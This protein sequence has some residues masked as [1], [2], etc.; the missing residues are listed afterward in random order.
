MAAWPEPGW[1]FEPG[2]P[3]LARWWDGTA[4]GTYAPAPMPPAPPAIDRFGL[5]VE[6]TVLVQ[7]SAQQLAA[8]DPATQVWLPPTGAPANASKS[9]T[10]LIVLLVIALLLIL[11][12]PAI[13]VARRQHHKAQLAAAQAAG[14]VPSNPQGP[15]AA[16]VAT[17][18]HPIFTVVTPPPAGYEG[19]AAVFTA[20]GVGPLTTPVF[21]LHGGLV[22]GMLSQAGD[23]AYFY[24][25]PENGQ[26]PAQPNETCNDGCT[27]RGW[28]PYRAPVPAGKYRLRVKAAAGTAWTFDLTEKL[29]AQLAYSVQSTSA[30]TT[31]S[32]HGIGN[33]QTKPFQLV[34]GPTDGEHLS[35]VGVFGASTAVVFTFVPVGNGIGDL[36]PVSHSEPTGVTSSG[37]MFYLPVPGTYELHVQATGPWHLDVNG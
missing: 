25:V 32:A 31:V 9:R 30:G 29:S 7:P 21:T 19:D 35:L 11:F 12:V 23:G 2:G 6:Q 4:W 33:Q 1:Y 17:R 28:A 22:R 37:V 24:L 3:Q 10:G 27:E 34:V 26:E 8:T 18:K 14:L 15:G 5:P 13:D 36:K 16:P 20:A